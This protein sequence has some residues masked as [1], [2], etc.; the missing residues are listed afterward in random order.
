MSNLKICSFK[1]NCRS[2]NLLKNN[3]RI[4]KYFKDTT[5]NSSSTT[6]L[7]F[8]IK[9]NNN[10]LISDLL[11]SSK[12]LVKNNL[13]YKSCT[14][15]PKTFQYYYPYNPSIIRSNSSAKNKTYQKK[16]SFNSLYKTIE[17]SSSK[18]NLKVYQKETKF[19]L[20]LKRFNFVNYNVNESIFFDFLDGYNINSK[21]KEK[22][23][24]YIQSHPMENDDINIYQLFDYV[25]NFKIDYNDNNFFNSTSKINKFKLKNNLSV[26][27]KISSLNLQFYSINHIKKN[28]LCNKNY[29]FDN[30]NNSKTKFRNKINTK[31]KLPFS[32]L[33]FFYGINHIVFL[34]FLITIITYD[35]DKNNFL[36]D[37][38]NFMK[39][40]K[41]CKKDNLFFGE[42]SYFQTFFNK[43]KEY[44]VYDWNVKNKNKKN[45]YIMKIILPQIKISIYSD[46]KI[47]SKFFYT[48][49]TNK[50][51]YLIKE[52]FKLWDFHVLKY[53]SELKLFRQ[54]INKI[55]CNKLSNGIKH[56]QT[57]EENKSNFDTEKKNY[58]KIFNLNNL[59]TKLNTLIENEYNYEF[60]FSQNINNKNESYFFQLQ[61]PKI[62]IIFQE[63]NHL[64]EKYFDLDIKRMSQINK[65]RKSFQ[66]E[67]IIKYSMVIVEQKYQKPLKK[68]GGYF[69]NKSFKRNLK[70]S[71]TLKMN[72]SSTRLKIR[73]VTTRGSVYNLNNL[74][75][76][77]IKFVG[78]YKNNGSIR[79]RNNNEE[80]KKDIKLNLDKYIF[81]FDDDILK[82]IKPLE[83][84]DN[85]EKKNYENINGFK[86]KNSFQI[87]NNNDNNKL[88][89][90]IG[91]IKLICKKNDLK[92]YEYYFEENVG[93][94]LL[95]NPPYIWE[96][97]IEN[98]L[99]E[100]IS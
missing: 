95:D 7:N 64:I 83:R 41:A 87:K 23:N 72:S 36:I 53:F 1:N 42:N 52:E 85:I 89:V 77:Q 29:L 3:I 45:H 11:N 37:F 16:L 61:I 33:P 59:N 31:L 90:E 70:R 14:E 43:N 39:N 67:D 74:A 66:I 6:P 34:K 48:I 62:H 26:K 60:F 57:K 54:E 84:K 8:Y 24:N 13:R 63:P 93:R 99:S 91:K 68:K 80:S 9:K 94:Y 27:I 56:F 78:S 75:S 73:T 98:K 19:K 86:E 96:N 2:A 20:H 12:K 92:E 55:I 18:K 51:V 35:Y 40:Y 46:N 22:Y 69:E 71:S 58:K 25:Q 88:S 15:L 82:F 30:S 32:F 4:L 21:I 50:M 28:N 100:I 81:N 97:Y 5:Y 17:Q 44:F 47:I 38:K 65:L 49:N 79:R 76:N 10:S